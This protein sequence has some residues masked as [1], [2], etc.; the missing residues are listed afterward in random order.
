MFGVGSGLNI[1]N[2]ISL[3]ARFAPLNQR[4]AVM[5]INGMVL[6]LGQTLGPIIMAVIYSEWGLD[7]VFYAGSIF[8]LGMCVLAVIMIKQPGEKGV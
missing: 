5:S 4:A 1:P 2:I 7:A 3:L 8:T 6:R